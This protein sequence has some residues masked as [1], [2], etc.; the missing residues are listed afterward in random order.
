MNISI[1]CITNNPRSSA[2]ASLALLLLSSGLNAQTEVVVEAAPN[3]EE[4]SG[5]PDSKSASATEEKPAAATAE[6]TPAKADTEAKP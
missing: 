2:I 1:N 3:T 6:E 5:T 4:P